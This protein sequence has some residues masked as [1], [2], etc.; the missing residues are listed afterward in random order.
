MANFHLLLRLRCKSKP[1]YVEITYFEVEAH[2]NRGE[3][4]SIFLTHDSQRFANSMISSFENV[5]DDTIL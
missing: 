1:L 5:A 3:K 4:S 2:A